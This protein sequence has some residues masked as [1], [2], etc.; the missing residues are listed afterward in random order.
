MLTDYIAAAMKRA[1]YKLLDDGTYFGEIPGFKGVWGNA[2]SL[3]ACRQEL[4]EALE[5]WLLI[6]L[7]KNTRLPVLN[8]ISLNSNRRTS[9]VA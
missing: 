9:R 5:G 4:Q 2:N 8:G 6:G 3:D 7:Q 1:K